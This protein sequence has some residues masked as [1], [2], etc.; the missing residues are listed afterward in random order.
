MAVFFWSGG[1]SSV[2]TFFVTYGV[3]HLHLA[4]GVAVITIGL[5]ALAYL[6]FAVPSGFMARRFGRRTLVL[7]GCFGLGLTF[8]AISTQDAVWPIRILALVGGLFWAL[9]NINGYPWITNLTRTSNVGAFTGLYL[10][11]AGL[12]NFVLQ[13]AIGFLMDHFGYPSLFV[14]AGGAALLAGL[15]LLASRPERSYVAS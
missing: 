4:S 7:V 8:L 5:F 13:P 6:I 3:Y 14:A 9:V 2:E 12:G 10:M 1:E 11:A 15:V